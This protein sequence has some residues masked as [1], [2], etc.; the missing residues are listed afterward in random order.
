M[1]SHGTGGELTWRCDGSGA[2]IFQ[3]KFY[4]DCNGINGPNSVMIQTTVPGLATIPAALVS[5]TDISPNGFFADGLTPCPDCPTGGVPA[6][7][8][9]IEEFVYE[10]QPIVINGT[11]PPTGWDFMW[12]ECCRSASLTNISSGGSVGFGFRATMYPYN[13]QSASPCFD[14][15]PVFAERPS[16]SVCGGGL[17]VNYEHLSEDAEFDSLVYEFVNPED[18]FG[19]VIPFAPGFTTQN[20]LPGICTLDSQTGELSYI[21]SSGGYF[22]LVIKVTS[23]KCGIKTAEIRR[24]IN[25]LISNNC[26][27]VNGGIPNEPPLLLPPFI[28]PVT[29]QQTSF[30]DTVIAGDTI[31]LVIF[32]ID[33]NLFTNA[34]PQSVTLDAFGH[35]YGNNFTDP[36]SGCLI[37]PCA[38]LNTTPPTT[39]LN[40]AFQAFNWTTTPAHLGY[41]FS[42]VQFTNTYYF[43]MKAADNY[44]P[45]NATNAKVFSITVLPS[46]P[47]PLVINNGGTLETPLLTNYIYQWFYNRF[48]IPGATSFSYTP[49]QPG[50]Y[51]VLTVA[52]DGQG[53]YS[54]GYYYN[55]LGIS[56]NSLLSSLNIVPNPS[57]D[58]VFSITSHASNVKN[59]TISVAD[60]YGKII[61]H[62]VPVFENGFSSYTLDLNDKASGVYTIIFSDGIMN[63]NIKVVKL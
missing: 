62:E 47:A 2:F 49:T 61:F 11:P 5:N 25:M 46:I 28:D 43:I 15:S 24:E 42:C 44:C 22:A 57:A 35:Q 33:S 23:Y 41:S 53:N 18:D 59:L 3:V 37:P 9:I 13:G 27:P 7:F 6:V 38:T 36:A 63:R 20:P 17:Q 54:N 14:S 34:S 26:A 58:G 40:N 52:P 30:A 60:V 12:G 45:A 4:R 51:Q 48:A 16:F 50:T 32:A 39:G 29:L 31:N 55:P 8:G 19:V 21:T 1:A 56:E 10:S